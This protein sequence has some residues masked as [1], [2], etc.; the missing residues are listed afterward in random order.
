MKPV[1][2]PEDSERNSGRMLLESP[3]RVLCIILVCVFTSEALI[4]LLLP[5]LGQ[6][7]IFLAAILDATLLL[8]ILTPLL[9]LLV[10]KPIQYQM[11]DREQAFRLL[12]ESEKRFQDIAANADEWIWEVDAQGRYTY[13]SPVIEAILGYTVEETLQ[14][15]FYDLFADEERE[16]L[17]EAAFEGFA[18]KQPFRNFI[19]RNL[20]KNGSS[21]WLSTS[22]V[23]ILDD[24]GE[25]LGYRGADS[26]KH[27]E[28]SITDLL[29]GVLNR[30]GF[31]LLANQHLKLTLRNR[32]SLAM[33]F[34]DIDDMK[35]INDRFG[36]AEGDRAIANVAAILTKSVR[37][38]DIVTRFG[39]DEFVVLLTMAEAGDDQQTVI[40]HI[41]D[42][43]ELFNRSPGR[44]FEISFS[45]GS[46]QLDPTQMSTLDDLI[47][48][49]DESMYRQKQV[50]TRR[51]SMRPGVSPRYGSP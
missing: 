12:R 16:A 38:A 8:L 14:K 18:A 42:E 30:H 48:R 47:R 7:P 20:H 3:G 21:V 23:P 35:Q 45:I 27:D 37:E 15:H 43:L 31:Q 6:L 34:V 29:S 26:L 13:V 41:T 46:A 2:K 40:R 51:R 11:K 9:Y 1:D 39:G 22:G 28:S 33:L 32:L 19:N 24:S 49:A 10:Y 17:K 4:M 44:R 50:S 36:H 25:L 5:T